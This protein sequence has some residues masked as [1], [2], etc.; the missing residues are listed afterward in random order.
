MTPELPGTKCRTSSSPGTMK[1]Q[2]YLLLRELCSF[3]VR[4]TAD[5]R[6]RS[7]AQVKYSTG[8]ED[9]L[10]L[11]SFGPDVPDDRRSRLSPGAA[12]GIAGG[13]IVGAVLV[14]VVA[15]LLV[16]RRRRSTLREPEAAANAA[17]DSDHPSAPASTTLGVSKHEKFELSAQDPRYQRAELHGNRSTIELPA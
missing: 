17:K 12:G 3:L 15:F 2:S 6:R 5:D 7:L 8:V 10:N 13:S 14:G 1:G 16:R 4:S 9:L 11:S